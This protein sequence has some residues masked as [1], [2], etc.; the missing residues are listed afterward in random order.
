MKG[1]HIN[2]TISYIEFFV[3]EWEVAKSERVG[4]VKSTEH[5]KYIY[6]LK[7]CAQVS[8]VD[9]CMLSYVLIHMS[10]YL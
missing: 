3:V 4:R 10:G 8:V 1:A 5:R 6:V 9:V 7:I 2:K